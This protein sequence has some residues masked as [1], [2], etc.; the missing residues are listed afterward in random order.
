VKQIVVL[1]VYI[2]DYYYTTSIT[3]I[4]LLNIIATTTDLSGII[5]VY[6]YIGQAAFVCISNGYYCYNM[7]H[8]GLRN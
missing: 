1:R 2:S 8:C 5:N 6:L 7:C 3:T 4:L